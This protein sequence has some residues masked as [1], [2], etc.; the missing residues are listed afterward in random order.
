MKILLGIGG[1][2]DS[3]TALRRVV[4]RT[5]ETGDDLVVAIIDNLETDVDP[6]E[7]EAR[8]REAVAGAGL[9]VADDPSEGV[10]IRRVEGHPG[11][12]LVEIADQENFDRIAL[13]GGQ[14]S[15]MG[16]IA[17]GEV[18]EFVLLN[19]RTTVTLVR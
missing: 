4:E 2:D 17:I 5:A 7:L 3:L 18:A 8:A 16:K 1:T 6:A 11:P 15:P 9:A 12:R 14:R 10:V 13:G 19:A